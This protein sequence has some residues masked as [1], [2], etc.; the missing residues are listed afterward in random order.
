MSEG[1]RTKLRATQSTPL[2]PE[3]QIPTI[4]GGER[5]HRQLNVREVYLVGENTTH[6]DDAEGLIDFVDAVHFHL[7]TAVIQKNAVASGNLLGQFVVGD[8]RHGLVAAHFF[9]VRE[10]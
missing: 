6:G 10:K 9:E 2:S 3:S 4:F 8:R 7:D 5:T 1:L